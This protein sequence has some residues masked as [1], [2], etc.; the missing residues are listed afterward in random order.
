MVIKGIATAGKWLN[1]KWVKEAAQTLE[2]GKVYTKMKTSTSKVSPMTTP[3]VK[4]VPHTKLPEGMFPEELS[5]KEIGACIATRYKNARYIAKDYSCRGGDKVSNYNFLKNLDKKRDK[6]NIDNEGDWVYRKP[7][8]MTD[9]IKSFEILPQERVSM[10][11]NASD[12]VIEAL[13]RYISKGELIVDGK[14]VKT[15]KPPKAYYKVAADDS[16]FARSEP[17]TMYFRE[18]V[19]KDMLEDITLITRPFK[20][21]KDVYNDPSF[22]A[23][24]LKSASWLSHSLEHSP[25]DL[26]KLYKRAQKISPELAEGITKSGVFSNMV[27]DVVHKEYPLTQKMERYRW[28]ISEGLYFAIESFV[29]DFEKALGKPMLDRMM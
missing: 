28:R 13:D 1:G 7:F 4:E 22:A 20:C 26:Y 27:P 3:I 5:S 9:R 14:V 25:E 21:A 24:Q 12:D 18:P 17:F 19:T 2:D 10:N 23:G 15:V 6:I 16:F 8:W 29:N 11:L